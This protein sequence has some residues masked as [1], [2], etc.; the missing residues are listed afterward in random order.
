MCSVHHYDFDLQKEF[1]LKACVTACSAPHYLQHMLQAEQLTAE[2][3]AYDRPSPKLLSFLHKHY[4]LAS[5]IPQSNNFV[6]FEAYFQHHS[7]GPGG[8][9]RLTRAASSG[10]NRTAVTSASMGT[11]HTGRQNV[12]VLGS[13]AAAGQNVTESWV[14]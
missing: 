14:S 13:A 11:L 6:V 4:G 7:V 10:S 1:L 12:H 2:Q 8:S 3:L 9:H 5:Y